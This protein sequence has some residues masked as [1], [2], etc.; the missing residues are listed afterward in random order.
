MRLAQ[1]AT[2]HRWPSRAF[3]GLVRAVAGEPPDVLKALH[4]RPAFWGAPYS[5]LLQDVMR[6]PSE[7][8]PG[9]RELFAA[10]RQLDQAGVSMIFASAID[11]S[12]LGV[13]VRDRL[14]RAAEGRVRRG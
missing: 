8:T 4:F 6:G 13:A 10:L 1:V 3:L 5:D 9:E 7:W 2:G 12:G 14:V 11:A